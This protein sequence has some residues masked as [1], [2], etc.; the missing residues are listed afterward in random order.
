[1][2]GR[3]NDN[4]LAQ[5]DR[6]EID[7]F[8]R[9]HWQF[10]KKHINI[11]MLAIVYKH[12]AIPIFWKLLDNGKGNSKKDDRIELIE[13]F[14]AT[15]PDITIVKLLAD[16][17]FVGKDWFKW[18]NKNELTFCI[19]I[20][21][22][23]VVRR[24]GRKDTVPVER[25]FG[26]VK[27]KGD[28]KHL[29]KAVEV[30]GQKLFLSAVRYEDGSLTILASNQFKGVDLLNE[31]KLRWQIETLFSCFKSRGLD[32]EASHLTLPERMSKLV[33]VLSLAFAWAYVSGE[34]LNKQKPIEMKFKGKEKACLA[35]SFFRVG[36]SH[37]AK[38]CM[39]ILSS[40]QFAF[41]PMAFI[42]LLR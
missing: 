18:L 15:F 13:L 42:H 5:I 4:G 8:D 26:E 23:N 7:T 35:F 30:C 3:P 31:Y 20:R 38:A 21:K 37:L 6:S 24:K 11:L 2:L 14:K 32:I 39:K 27:C 17:E 16:R 22:N 12:V 9:T 10:S 1:M 33:A 25:L 19:P 28:V 40:F 36:L 41:E 29:S 34:W